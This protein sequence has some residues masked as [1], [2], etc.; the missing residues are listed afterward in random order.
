MNLQNLHSAYFIGIGG[1]GMSAIARFLHHKGVAVSGFDRTPSALCSEMIQSGIEI[2][3]SDAQSAI[4][5]GFLETPLQ[6]TVVIY[7]PAVPASHPQLQWLHSAGYQ[8]IKRAAALATITTAYR[9]IAVAGTHGKTTTSAMLAHILIHSGLGCQAFLG[10]VSTNYQ[11]NLI[12]HPTSDLAVVEADEFD[13]SFHALSPRWGIITSVEADHLDIYGHADQLREAFEGFAQRINPEGLLLYREGIGDMPFEGEALSYGLSDSADIKGRE[14]HVENGTF[15]FDLH[16]NNEHFQGLE[17]GLPGRHN[18]ENAVAAAGIARE[19]QVSEDAIRGA[20]SSFKG[21]KRRFERYDV[22]PNR[23]FIDDYAHHPT[24]VR[25]CGQAVKELY[26]EREI[27]VVFQPHLYSRTRDFAAEFGA[28]LSQFHRVILL[29]IYPAREE[30]IPGVSSEMILAHVDAPSKE[31]L[32]RDA[33]LEDLRNTP[34]DVL[35]TLGAGDIDL[36]VEPIAQFI[37]AL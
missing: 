5:Q 24:E 12:T 11:S 26:P 36:L 10:G 18:V 20:L 3:Y 29:D 37:K 27:T 4:P 35:L 6:N 33:L 15:V 13:R 1:I 17:L 2:V 32:Q 25:A 16:I 31:I 14:V 21:V 9:T 23:V 7:T 34:P 22:G 8:V 28:A 30:A 19:L